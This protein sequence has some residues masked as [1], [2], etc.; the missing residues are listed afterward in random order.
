ML[1]HLKYCLSAQLVLTTLTYGDVYSSE[2]STAQQLAQEQDDNLFLWLADSGQ[3]AGSSSGSLPIQAVPCVK[4][5]DHFSAFGQMLYLKPYFQGVPVFGIGNQVSQSDPTF[6]SLPYAY[7]MLDLSWDFGFRVGLGFKANWMGLEN[8]LIWM[9]YH[10]ANQKQ[11]PQA[12]YPDL[13]RVLGE[14]W[15]SSATARN[16]RA[17]KISS[18]TS[19]DLDMIDLTSKIPLTPLKKVMLAPKI[20]VRGLISNIGFFTQ[21]IKTAYGNT[22]DVL[23]PPQNITSNTLSEK[24]NAVGLVSGFDGDI[25]LGK[26]FHFDTVFNVAA[27]FGQVKTENIA[28]ASSPGL[29]SSGYP[30]ANNPV[31]SSFYTVLPIIDAQFK[32]AWRKE[33]FDHKMS[34]DISVGYE[35]EYMPSFL[36]LMLVSDFGDQVDQYDFSMQGLNAGIRI[37]F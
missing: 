15:N 23:T 35:F 19:I 14:L 20:G 21:D 8:Q 31:S 34:F 28:L 3:Q 5:M 12:S 10:T 17:F 27:T 7:Q 33:C 26:G 32:L 4:K 22:Q 25:D 24:Y 11:Y 13:T 1:K 16:G 30:D 29:E 36:Q 2:R 37:C 9:R 6:R 18:N